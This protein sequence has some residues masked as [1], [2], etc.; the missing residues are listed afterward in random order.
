MRAPPNLQCIDAANLLVWRPR[1]IL[2]EPQV[3]QIIAHLTDHENKL[4]QSLNRFTDLSLLDA[5]DLS[6]KYVFQVA[7]Y[8]RISRLGRDP[9]KSAFFVTSPVVERYVKLH[10]VLTDYS[11]LQVKLFEDRDA[12]AKWLG[13]E[14]GLLVPKE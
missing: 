8:R 12:A 13:V 4:G 7:L 6:F 14:P 1:G 5:V 9:I 11:P 2:D 3:D 10:A